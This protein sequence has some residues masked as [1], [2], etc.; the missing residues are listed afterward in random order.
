[1]KWPHLENPVSVPRFSPQVFEGG[2][3]PFTPPATRRPSPGVC[4]P[5]RS[6]LPP[7]RAPAPSPRQ[8][9]GFPR[10]RAETRPSRARCWARFRDGV[11][12]A[13]SKTRCER[14]AW[15]KVGTN[16]V[17]ADTGRSPWTGASGTVWNST[18]ARSVRLPAR[19]KSERRFVRA[20][21]VGVA[22]LEQETKTPPKTQEPTLGGAI[23]GAIEPM[24]P[25]SCYPPA[26]IDL[27]R[28]L[29]A[30]SPAEREQILKIL[31]PPDPP[32]T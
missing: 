17:P 2:S 11:R 32:R 1:M 7:P 24:S 13:T 19:R 14:G 22:G 4:G 29:A 18:P 9:M 8:G 26:V 15:P 30:L 6:R 12:S 3:T 21:M 20:G 5:P 16:S 25:V 23:S 28:R 10:H 31:Q 27:A